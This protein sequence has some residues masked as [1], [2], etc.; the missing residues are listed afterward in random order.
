M[1]PIPALFFT[2]AALRPV[3]AAALM[4]KAIAPADP[5]GPA[6][7]VRAISATAQV[8]GLV[9]RLGSPDPIAGATL[10][11]L[12]PGPARDLGLSGARGRFRFQVPIGFVRL[13]ASVDGYAPRLLGLT[14]SAGADRAVTLDLAQT[15]FEDAELVVMAHRERAPVLSASLSREEIKHIPGV[16]GDALR[17]LQNL[18]GVAIPS[19]FSGEMAVQGGGPG[20][21][22][23][24]LDNIPWPFPFH[25]GGTLSTVNSD[26]LAGADLNAAGF[27]ARWGNSLDAVLDARTSAGPRDRIHASA[28]L[29]LVTSQLM[30]EGPLG[31]G[32]LSFTL[33][34][35]RSYFDLILPLLHLADFTALPVFWDLGGSLDWSLGPDN[36]FHALALSNDDVM[37]VVVPAD[38][39]PDVQLQGLFSLHN[40]ATTS[41]G[42]WTNTSLPGLR[43]V[44]SPY[45]Y[46]VGVDDSVGTGF[47]IH[48]HNM[49]WG[50]KEELTYALSPR[51]ELDFGGGTQWTLSDGILYVFD[52]NYVSTNAN[53]SPTAASTTATAQ[54]ANRYAY[55]SDRVQ[56]LPGLAAT[57]GLRYDK[58]DAVADDEVSPRLGL[59][60]KGP[61]GLL[62]KAAWGRYSQFPSALN[63]DPN[64]G[65]PQLTAELAEHVV[66]GVDKDLG[67]GRIFH[68]D[69]FYKTY[70]DLVA[71]LPAAQGAGEVNGGDGQARGVDVLLRQNLG[72]HFFGWV[73][74]TWSKSE[75][76]YPGGDWSLY[77]YD[78][79]HILNV[80][81]FYW[82]TPAWGLGLKLHYNSGPLYQSMVPNS[83]YQDG[84]GNWHAVFSPTYDQRLA[85]Y[86]RLDLRTDYAFR[87]AG[88]RLNAYLEVLN[89][90]GRPNPEG[91]QYAKDYSSYSVINN[92]P[93]LPYIGL[94][95]EY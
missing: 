81:G 40:A 86:L 62:W 20:D 9:R 51:Q 76:L 15:V 6:V 54:V 42:S 34:G 95:A 33:A 27:P 35:R 52:K 60:W 80:V 65:N 11:L 14:L 55:L 64:F 50:L 30:V 91:I 29:S 75:R 23:Y 63:L 59:E 79:T 17:A 2:L 82:L 68:L 83:Q 18:P 26:L 48:Q 39:A 44:L 71:N 46:T 8:H 88:W 77:Q 47:D 19:D 5:A 3:S 56:V 16:D 24:L 38:K 72:S 93:F 43:S 67:L 28:D 22:L 84:S 57:L 7:E 45:Y 37:G 41:G 74:Y 89:A 10:E 1:Q 31:L 70:H 32:D 4:V 12:A 13:R 53:L 25:F 78:Q 61:G 73:A 58:N 94:Q 90:L 85:D 66:L 92:L 69:G 87:F 36:H 21:N 49:A